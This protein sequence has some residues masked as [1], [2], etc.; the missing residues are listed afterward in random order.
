[1]FTDISTSN[2]VDNTA[3]A[4]H[5]RAYEVVF[6]SDAITQTDFAMHEHVSHARAWGDED[7]FYAER[8]EHRVAGELDV[9]DEHRDEADV[10][11]L[12]RD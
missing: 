6:A 9:V 10:V 11:E 7:V 2:G 3:R 8:D 5:E 12:A 4:A 1:V